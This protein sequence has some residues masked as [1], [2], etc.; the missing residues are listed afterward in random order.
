[1]T[2]TYNGTTAVLYVDGVQVASDTFTAPGA[3]HLPMYVGRYFQGG[4]GWNG[5]VDE[6]RLYNR[7]LTTAEVASIAAG[8]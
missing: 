5:G 8:H 2:A 1:V 6:L 3:T 7:A 4:Y